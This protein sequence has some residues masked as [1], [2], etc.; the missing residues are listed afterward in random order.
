VLADAQA[1]DPFR[2]DL[3][4]SLAFSTGEVALEPGG[5]PA[6]ASVAALWNGRRGTV[7]VVLSRAEPAGV[8]SFR[9]DG[10]LESEEAVNR[11]MEYAIGYAEGLGFRMQALP[12]PELDESERAAR[13]AEW[14]EIWRQ[15]E[16][17]HG[18]PE[19]AAS[20][21]DDLEVGDPDTDE[22]A[23]EPGKVVLARI[24]LLRRG[25][26]AA[27]ARILAYF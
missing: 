22:G 23:G 24:P 26:R 7:L 10:V 25:R 11:A 3:I 18:G 4:R 12:L 17:E 16:I 13:L 1:P 8:R 19:L 20:A 6:S 9:V 27:L 14:R 21:G 15:Y 5:Q 2:A